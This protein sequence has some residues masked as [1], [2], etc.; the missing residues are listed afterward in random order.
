MQAFLR[1]GE[2]HACLHKPKCCLC[3]PVIVGLIRGADPV[4]WKGR[5]RAPVGHLEAS[6]IFHPA[7]TK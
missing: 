1:G 7:R 6:G 2:R 4:P 5:Q 3:A